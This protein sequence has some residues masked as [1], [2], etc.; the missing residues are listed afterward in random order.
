MAR[1]IDVSDRGIV[2]PASLS[3]SVDV[4]FDDQRVW[5]FSP[6]HDGRPASQQQLLV[7]WPKAL[8]RHLDGTA[9][10]TLVDHVSRDVLHA[11][12]VRFAAGERAGA[13]RRRRGPSAGRRQGRAAAARLQ[14]HRGLGPRRDHGRLG[15]GP[16]RPRRRVRSRRLP[17][18]RLPARRRP[19][20]PHD[21]PRLGRRRRLPLQARA[22]LR[23]HPR[24]HDRHA[25]DAIA[26]LEGRADVGRELQGLGA[27]S[28]RPAGG[29][30]RVRL[31]PR[32]GRFHVTGS[33]TGTLDRSALVPFGTV[34]LEGREIV[35]PA[36]P[37]EVLAFT[38]GPVVAS[39]RS[40]VPLRPRPGRR[41]THGRVVPLGAPA[42][43]LLERLLQEPGRRTGAR[44]SR[45]CSRSGRRRG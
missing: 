14:Q 9:D 13:R 31:V 23:H 25:K 26:R 34:T 43:A 11:Q 27:A 44:S 36:K 21:R 7:D 40:G 15:E 16:P 32:D 28:R 20:R 33:L 39:A 45:R 2:V 42:T 1:G 37:E 12:Q 17:D 30:R 38:Y 22:S 24:V 3:A 4:L 18:V 10:V 8:R 41:T 19:R 35:A 5:S 29:H 6:G